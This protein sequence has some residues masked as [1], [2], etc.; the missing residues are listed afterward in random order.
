MDKITFC[1]PSKS[2]L[3][4][5]KS[6]VKSIRDN[7][8]RSDHYISVFVDEDTDGTVE[9]LEANA[10]KYSI[11]FYIN[12]F[13]GNKL[14]GIGKAYDYLIERS[15]T[16]VFMIFHADMI[17]GKHADLKAFEKLEENTV[18]AS[19]RIEPPLHPNAGEKI[20]KDF[21][22][23]PED[24][25]EEDFNEYVDL[26]LSEEKTTEGI[27]APWM[28]YKDAF[29]KIGGHDPRMHSCREDSDVFNRLHLAGF[30][31]IQPWNSLV[32]HFTG[33]GAGSFD[34]DKERHE[35]WKKDMNNSTREFIRK[36]KSN[37]KHSPLM[38]PIVS[39]VYDIGIRVTNCHLQL[40]GLLEPWCNNL[41]VDCEYGPYIEAEQENTYD[42]LS[43]KIIP[44]N[45]KIEN[46]I[47][48]DL[49]GKTFNQ[50]DFAYLQEI[51]QIIQQSGQVGQSKLGQT[52]IYVTI[53]K[54]KE[55]QKQL[56]N[57]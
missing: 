7:A 22:L 18:V 44:I 9:W 37:V 6:A 54:L 52:N 42:I 39:P 24:F 43:T 12:P 21:G 15:K 41:F 25:K 19:T 2:N 28:M 5:L 33:R 29:L 20:L 45:E 3:R 57:L 40:V 14:F 11:D 1:L 36:W 23:Y 34:G 47:I 16:D 30:K 49:D 51:S 35:K 8:Y 32:Y 27:F 10:E 56:V 55:Y 48:I 50:Q 13:L 26:N 46:D 38:L 53:N 17:L 4:Y 31:F